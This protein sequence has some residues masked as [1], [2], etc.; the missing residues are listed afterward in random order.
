MKKI[1]IL[2]LSVLTLGLSVA[3]CSSDDDENTS[4]VGKWELIK[5][6][7]VISGQEVIGDVENGTC[8]GDI[9]EYLAD[10][11]FNEQTFFSED[12]KCESETDK[13][14]YTVKE[15]TLNMKYEGDTSGDNSEILELNGST[16]KLKYVEGDFV[17]IYVYKRK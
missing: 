3:S 10:G 8:G 11:S 16:L 17:H 6:G 13:G 14:T 12:S 7:T 1:T 9:T 2:F 5:E 15:K 4:I